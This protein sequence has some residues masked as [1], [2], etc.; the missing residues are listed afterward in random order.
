MNLDKT[1]PLGNEK[2]RPN[3][4]IAAKENKNYP[5]TRKKNFINQG[6]KYI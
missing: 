2:R 3:Q 5:Q 4:A 1:Q 6:Q